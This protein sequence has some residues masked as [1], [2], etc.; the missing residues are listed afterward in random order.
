MKVYRIQ[1][2]KTLILLVLMVFSL[3]AKAQLEHGFG[4]DGNN[5]ISAIIPPGQSTVDVTLGNPAENAQNTQY[6]W[7]LVKVNKPYYQCTFSPGWP[8]TKMPVATLDYGTWLFKVSRASKYGIQVEYVVVYV[9]NYIEVKAKLKEGRCCWSPGEEIS[10]NDFNIETFPPGM[11]NYVD[12]DEGCREA[13]HGAS[14]PETEQTVIFAPV[15]GCDYEV[16]GQTTITVIEGKIHGQLNLVNDR[17]L[18]RARGALLAINHLDGMKDRFKKVEQYLNPIKKLG[19][20]DYDYNVGGALNF[21]GGEECCCGEKHDFLGISGNVYGTLSVMATF[22]PFLAFPPF[23]FKFG[24]EGG[25][26]L[27]LADLKFSGTI[28]DEGDCGCSGVDLIPFSV[29]ADIMGGI[30][31]EGPAADVLSATGLLVGGI[32]GTLNYTFSDGWSASNWDMYFKFRAKVC[33]LFAR[34]QYEWILVD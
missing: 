22:T 33:L 27:T 17:G 5:F 16:H 30:A 19:P 21:Y 11:E 13:V 34:Y 1:F 8:N 6:H 9:S 3:Q 7:D 10:M 31:F 29:Y 26:S 4:A 25:I 28:F 12:L 15:S 14:R 24:V 20:F 18:L 2:F 23:K 32:T